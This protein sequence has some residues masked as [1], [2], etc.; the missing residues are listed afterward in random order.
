MPVSRFG[1][2]GNHVFQKQRVTTSYGPFKGSKASQS[3]HLGVLSSR[4]IDY[5]GLMEE[6][7]VKKRIEIRYWIRPLGTALPT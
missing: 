1:A 2:R 3:S 5:N 4:R 7:S 6:G